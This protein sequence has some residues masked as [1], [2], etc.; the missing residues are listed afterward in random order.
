MFLERLG[1]LVHNADGSVVLRPAIAR[2]RSEIR[3]PE[4]FDV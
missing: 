2:Y 4:A 1:L 3:L